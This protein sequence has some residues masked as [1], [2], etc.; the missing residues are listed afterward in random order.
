MKKNRE[1]N[2]ELM[3]LISMF[4]IVMWHILVHGNLFN[5][6]NDVMSF[7]GEIILALL[8]VHVNSLVFLMGYFNGSN[9]KIRKEKYLKLIGEAWFY[10]AIIAIIFIIFQLAHLSHITIFEELLPL[11]F[12]NYWFLNC[13]LI[14]YI[15]SPY[16]NKV[17]EKLTE[18]EFLRFILILVFLLTIL[19]IISQ[20]RILSNNGSNVI[21]FI[22]VYYLGSYFK[23]YPL[24]EN[25]HFKYFSKKKLQILLV[26]MLFAFAILNISTNCLGE[27]MYNLDN[28]FFQYIGKIIL[29]TFTSYSNPFVIAQAC[30]YCLL[31]ETFKIKSKIIN[32]CAASTFGIYLIHDNHLVRKE[33]Y[34]WTNNI[35]SI[36]TSHNI[37]ILLLLTVIIYISCFIIETI[38]RELVKTSI[39]LYNKKRNK[40][41]RSKGED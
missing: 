31:F 30:A 39:I 10:K 18:K 21:N 2:F 33:L 40:F 32:Y 7:T 25:Y 12:N 4:M 20:N 35:K 36:S 27:K 3:R 19:P 11:D 23:K 34:N 28:E 5:K 22:I 9:K 13:Y 38:R 6:V 14:V 24:S 26:I 1:S 29:S 15:L 8:V 17:T 37:V 16:L 41:Q